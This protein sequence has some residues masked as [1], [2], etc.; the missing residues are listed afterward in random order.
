MCFFCPFSILIT[1]LWVEGA[2]LRASRAF[3]CLFA[4][5]VLV[6]VIF[7]LP[8]GVWGRL[9]FVLWFSLDFSLT[10]LNTTSHWVY[11]AT[12]PQIRFIYLANILLFHLLKKLQNERLRMLLGF[13]SFDS[14]ESLI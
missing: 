12:G 1:S 7:S 9:R 14:F 3:V 8:L 6:F 4:L 2:G 10:F 11:T 5:Y 13:D